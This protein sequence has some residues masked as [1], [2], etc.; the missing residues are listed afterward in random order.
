LRCKIPAGEL[1]LDDETFGPLLQ[2]LGKGPQE[3]HALMQLPVFVAAGEERC[4]DAINVLLCLDYIGI[5]TAVDAVS[6]ARIHAL[7]R[8]LM[9]RLR[10]GERISGFASAALGAGITISYHDLLFLCAQRA[11]CERA[12]DIAAFAQAILARDVANVD[13]TEL[14]AR[15]REVGDFLTYG[16]DFYRSLDLF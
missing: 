16:A 7:N 1:Q 9:E 6:A 5:L 4:I 8:A 15:G 12:E 11:G 3:M 2:S 10:G 13:H 14:E